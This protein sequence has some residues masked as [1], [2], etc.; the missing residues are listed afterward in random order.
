M[1]PLYLPNR[2]TVERLPLGE[3]A[4]FVNILPALVRDQPIRHVSSY[5]SFLSAMAFHATAIANRLDRFPTDTRLAEPSIGNTLPPRIAY[6]L[7]RAG[8]ATV[9]DSRNTGPDS[10][11]RCVGVWAPA[12]P[13]NRPRPFARVGASLSRARA[14]PGG[15]RARLLRDEAADC[16][17]DGLTMGRF[18]SRK[19]CMAWV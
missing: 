14:R 4:L 6:G 19:R 17:F 7:W 2:I 18:P 1:G 9:Y 13:C 15:A 11:A 16:H 3:H 12:C 10:G 5:P 8:L